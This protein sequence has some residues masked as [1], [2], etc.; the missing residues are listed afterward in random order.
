MACG[1]V[2]VYDE[3]KPKMSKI[4][5]RKKKEEN[6]ANHFANIFRNAAASFPLSTLPRHFRCYKMY[7]VGYKFVL[8]PVSMWLLFSSVGYTAIVIALIK[9]NVLRSYSFMIE[10]TR[11]TMFVLTSQ[12]NH[13]FNLN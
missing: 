7:Y 3:V 11:Y 10:W 12:N 8:S 13:R 5:E 9:R 2:P 6:Q 1:A 4:N